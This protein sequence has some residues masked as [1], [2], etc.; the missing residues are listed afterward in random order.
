VTA[1]EREAPRQFAG[2]GISRGRGHYPKDFFKIKQ[3][4][5]GPRARLLAKIKAQTERDMR[6]M[7]GF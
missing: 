2:G 4:D 5:D 7:A 1:T 3:K 6:D